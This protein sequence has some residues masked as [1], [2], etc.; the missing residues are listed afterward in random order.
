M[1]EPFQM[2]LHNKHVASGVQDVKVIVEIYSPNILYARRL[3]IKILT[4][5]QPKHRTAAR[6]YVAVSKLAG[7]C[8]LPPLLPALRH[9]G[10]TVTLLGH[11]QVL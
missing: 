8:P 10:R 2:K 5:A 11:A 9:L 1:K 4:V 7:R 3:Y 6:Q